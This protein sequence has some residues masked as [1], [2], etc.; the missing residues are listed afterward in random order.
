MMITL[1]MW[2]LGVKMVFLYLV[3]DPKWPCIEPNLEII[4]ANIL[5]NIHDDHLKNVTSKLLIFYLTW[6][7]SFLTTSDPLSDLI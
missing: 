1:K 3:F 7:L 6:W 2:P 4:K 5:S